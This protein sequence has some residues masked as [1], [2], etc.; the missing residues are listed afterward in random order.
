MIK[1]WQFFCP[2]CDILG[3]SHLI[4]YAHNMTVFA[5]VKM[6]H[7]IIKFAAKCVNNTHKTCAACF[8]YTVVEHD[9]LVFS[10]CTLGNIDK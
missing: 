6:D 8:R 1:C 9:C 10:W 5:H 7:I 4:S 3:K 2:C